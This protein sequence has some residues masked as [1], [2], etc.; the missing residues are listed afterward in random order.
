MTKQNNFFKK[1]LSVLLSLS[2]AFAA[3]GV[4][5]PRAEAKSLSSLKDEYAQMEEKV[6]DSENK[7]AALEKQQ[8]RQEEIISELNN[9]ISHLNS[10]LENVQ[11]QKSLING[12]IDKTESKINTINSEIA[13]LN[14]EIAQKDKEIEE[15]VKLFCERMRANYVAGRTSALELLTAS[16]D[17]AS[18]LN[19]IELFKR[20]T[21]SDQS[22][23]DALNKEIASIKSMQKKLENNKA[24]LN[25]EKAVLEGKRSDLQTAENELSATQAAIRSKSE[26]VYAKLSALNYQTKKLEVSIAEYNARMDK[27]DDEITEFLQNQNSSSSGGSSGSESS[28]ISSSGWAW[29]VPYSSSYISSPFGYRVDPATGYY[30]FHQGIDITMGGALGK[31]LVATK[32]GTV[33]LV[34]YQQY[35][36]GNYLIIDHGGGYASVYGHCNSVAA[37][38]GQRVSQGQVVAYIGETG[39]ATGPHVHFEIR[40]NGEKL[41]PSNFVS[42]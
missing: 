31:K 32:A 18:F 2:L 15:T 22:L 41:N 24:K 34:D 36:Y 19:R 16:S 40:Y 33:I 29:P 39:Y 9:Q 12:D 5:T 35:G 1:T 25:E 28:N 42:K 11:G 14:E 38:V 23:V 6:K 3:F 37:Y 8:A 13:Q 17:L 27:I 21:E 26:E 10:E 30:K 4:Y 20:V 7:I